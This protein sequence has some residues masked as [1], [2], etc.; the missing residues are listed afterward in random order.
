GADAALAAA[1]RRLD[2]IATKAG[3]QIEP[4]LAA[5]D[6]AAAEIAD[7]TAELQ[8]LS[9][10]PDLDPRRLEQVEDRLFAL[11]DLSRKHNT[12]VDDLAQ[13]RDEFSARLAAV[14]DQGGTLE[15]LAK[16]EA[17]A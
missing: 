15:R 9:A 7:A 2:R 4:I 8:R 6:R 5:L 14:E 1:Q 17:V 16:E 13:L 11:R 10:D 12:P 3:S